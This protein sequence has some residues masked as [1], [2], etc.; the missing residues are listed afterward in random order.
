MITVGTRLPASV[1]SCRS[2]RQWNCR[3]VITTPH[4][5]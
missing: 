5:S 2:T 3:R 1:N 4:Q